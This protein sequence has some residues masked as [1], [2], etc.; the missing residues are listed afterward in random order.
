M[1]KVMGRVARIAIILALVA[2][3]MVLF[4]EVTT[5]PTEAARP[6]R[7]LCGWTSLWDCTL[8]DGSHQV[9]VGTR[10]D[11]QQFEQQTG[12]TCVLG[13]F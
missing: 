7:L 4:M 5:T 2:P 1:K 11:I 8:P 10:C 9:V 6:G 13:G 3:A 12:A